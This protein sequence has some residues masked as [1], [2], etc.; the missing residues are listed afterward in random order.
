MTKLDDIRAGL[1]KSEGEFVE[2]L[3]TADKASPE[4]RAEAL[5]RMNAIYKY[6]TLKGRGRFLAE[7]KLEGADKQRKIA[8]DACQ[9]A[10]KP[11]EECDALME[12]IALFRPLLDAWP[13]ENTGVAWW[14]API[15]HLIGSYDPSSPPAD[16]LADWRDDAGLV[17]KGADYVEETADDVGEVLEDV[18]EDIEETYDEAQ[19][20]KR[21]AIAWGRVGLAVGATAITGALVYRIAKGS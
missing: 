6:A 17:A 1:F 9:N 14:S 12:S 18:L 10:G 4:V 11:Q 2:V 8:F 13:K 15:T 3:K 20:E 19:E 5:A 21:K 7:M 16:A